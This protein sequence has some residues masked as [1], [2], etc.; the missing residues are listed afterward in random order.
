MN[1]GKDIGQQARE[2]AERKLQ[3]IID[4]EGDAGGERRKPYYLEKLIDEEKAAICW[5]LMSLALMELENIKI[6]PV[7]T[8]ATEATAAH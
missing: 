5:T 4:R 2:A 8:K 1:E 7:P 3:R 6:A